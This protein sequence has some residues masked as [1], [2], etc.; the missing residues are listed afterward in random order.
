MAPEEI[1]FTFLSP[2]SGA[3]LSKVLVCIAGCRE[4]EGHTSFHS[5]SL[6]RPAALEWEGVCRA[7]AN[8]VPAV[9]L[10]IIVILVGGATSCCG[11]LR[12]DMSQE[13][14]V[15]H[16]SLYSLSSGGFCPHLG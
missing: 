2:L 3:H 9:V 13:V 4:K 5:S 8:G 15:L 12:A 6:L 1:S 14:N 10:G 16:L 11:N 7:Q